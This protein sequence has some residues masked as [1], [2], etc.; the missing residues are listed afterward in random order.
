MCINSLKYVCGELIHV[1]QRHDLECHQTFL[2]LPEKRKKNT[3]NRVATGI[4][5]T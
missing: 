2:I 1:F 4:C 5:L 3:I